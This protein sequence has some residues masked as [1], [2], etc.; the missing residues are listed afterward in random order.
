MHRWGGRRRGAGRK[1]NAHRRMVPHR[2][3]LAHEQRCPAHVT[4]R[5]STAIPSLRDSCVFAATARALSAAGRRGFRVVQYSVQHDH[6]HLLVEADTPAGFV[7]GLQGLC[8]RVAKAIDRALR[9]HGRVWADRYHARLL[10]TPREV[11]RSSTCS[12]TGANTSRARAG[13]MPDRRQPG[14]TVGSTGR[15][16]PKSHHEPRRREPGSCASD[17]GGVARS[18]STT[19]RS[20][21]RD[22]V[23]ICRPGAERLFAM[24][25]AGAAGGC[26]QTAALPAR[27]V[28]PSMPAVRAAGYPACSTQPGT[29]ADPRRPR[30]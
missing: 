25:R 29:A 27:N 2:R 6:V 3:R 30:P 4:L 1:P 16:P 26:L 7:R 5:A 13:S 24:S 19:R 10:R 12:T 17:G 21:H 11:T 8:I 23:D 28:A 9:R 15:G 22:A 20:R 14:S 18:A